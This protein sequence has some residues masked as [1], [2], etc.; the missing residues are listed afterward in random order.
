MPILRENPD[1][2]SFCENVNDSEL[3]D[4]I[5]NEIDMGDDDVSKMAKEF[6]LDAL[7]E[8]GGGKKF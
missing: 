1:F 2:E 4:G 8:H 6:W 3:L 7:Q 5:D